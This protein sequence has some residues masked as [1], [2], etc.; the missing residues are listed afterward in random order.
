[1][2]EVDTFPEEQYTVEIPAEFVNK[3]GA[4][5]DTKEVTIKVLGIGEAM[6]ISDQALSVNTSGNRSAKVNY[7]REIATVS[8]ITKSVIKAPWKV[9]DKV[10]AARIPKNLAEWLLGVIEDGGVV[11]EKKN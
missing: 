10:V 8:T 3:Y 4:N 7:L 1:M 2:P 6:R 11:D 9:N 5:W